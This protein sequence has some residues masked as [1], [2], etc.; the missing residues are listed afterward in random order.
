MIRVMIVDDHAIVRQGLAGF[1]NV[2][3]DMHLV[4]DIENA[5]EVLGACAEYSPDVI[6]MDMVLPDSNGVELTAQVKA[7][8]PSIQILILSS[9]VEENM[10]HDALEAG[11]VGYLLKNASIHEM[12]AAIRSVYAGETALSQVATQALIRATRRPRSPDFELTERERDMLALL[13]QG[14]S[15]PQIAEHLTL[16]LSTVKFHVSNVLSKLSVESRTEAVAFALQ[17]GL[18]DR[19]DNTPG[20]ME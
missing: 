19:P 18:V 12:A 13:V 3:K 7:H 20:Q 16:S 2:F 6:L 1:L 17:H 4:A 5:D 11:A 8:F 10:V 15:N 14:Y 9:F